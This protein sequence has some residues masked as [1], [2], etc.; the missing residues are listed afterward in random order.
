MN[1][2]DFKEVWENQY[3]ISHYVAPVYKAIADESQRGDLYEGK[4]LHRTAVG[5]FYVNPM[6]STGAYS[7]QPWTE[8]DETLTINYA[9]EVS[10]TI[11]EQDK[12]MTHL[13]T[14]VKRS[15]KSMNRIFNQVDADVFSVAYQGAGSVIDT[16]TISQ[17]VSDIGTPITVS[18]ANIP[19]IFF[20]AEQQL[21]QNNV[22]YTPTGKWTGQ[23]KID[24]SMNVPVAVISSQM[25]TYLGLYLGGK[26][27]ALGDRVT[28]SGNVGQ[29]AGFNVFVSNALPWST[30]IT[31]GA[32]PTAGDTLTFLSGVSKNVNG[33]VQAQTLTFTFVATIGSTP[34]NVL[35]G[36]N[37]A[38]TLTNLAAALN[39]PFTTTASYVGYTQAS[40]YVFQALFFTGTTAT[41]GTTTI[42]IRTKGMGNVPM[43]ATFANGTNLITN[44]VQHNLFG[45][46]RSLSLVMPRMAQITERPTP[47]YT[48]STDYIAWTYYGIKVF[49]DQAP[50][51]VDV[52]INAAGFTSMANLTTN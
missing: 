47:A 45:V 17:Q 36:G 2:F 19:N 7:P 35:I 15:E 8:A 49:A 18:Q 6:G 33:V 40:I 43:T 26:T 24:K 25:Y 23:Y 12:F 11:K 44:Q 29:F 27:T 3:E 28:Q 4:T 46:S 52:Q 30:T 31:L 39:A 50:G 42:T 14:A 16:S 34:G 32:N 10:V 22:E 41:A 20:A 9:N 13:P 51:L 48:V 37:A 38:A 5:D 1:T 21:I